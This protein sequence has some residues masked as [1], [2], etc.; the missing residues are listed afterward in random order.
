MQ[1]KQSL[2]KNKQKKVKQKEIE[3]KAKQ[4]TERKR[5][6]VKEKVMSAVSTA[7]DVI[8]GINASLAKRRSESYKARQEKNC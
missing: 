3:V 7:K 2:K 6:L 4:E 5:S 1:K 8:G